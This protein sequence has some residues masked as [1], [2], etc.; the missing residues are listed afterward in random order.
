M[1][2][3]PPRAA[4]A[5]RHAVLL[6]WWSQGPQKSV[7]AGPQGLPSCRHAVPSPLRHFYVNFR[8]QRSA[9][10]SHPVLAPSR[11]QREEGQDLSSRVLTRTSHQ[12]CDIAC[13]TY[14]EIQAHMLKSCPPKE[15]EGHD[16]HSSASVTKSMGSRAK[17][18]GRCLPLLGLT[19]GWQR[20]A[21]YSAL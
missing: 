21:L 3:C 18:K 8:L 10:K 13:S 1:L 11:S 6:P 17:W 12:T 16:D 20:R 5:K 14:T 9:K 15:Q 2:S 19:V 4:P 7:P